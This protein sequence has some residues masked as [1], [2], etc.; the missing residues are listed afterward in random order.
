[1]R[2]H[3]LAFGVAILLLTAAACTKGNGGAEGNR[4][5]SQ[6]PAAQKVAGTKTNGRG[7]YTVRARGRG[8]YRVTVRVSGFTAMSKAI[9]AGR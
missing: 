5:Q 9:R 2:K 7:F 8:T 4:T 6:T 3:A 1:M